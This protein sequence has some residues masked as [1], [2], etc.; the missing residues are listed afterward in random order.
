MYH[1]SK[2]IL[3]VLPLGTISSMSTML[4]IL[5][6]LE[7]KCHEALKTVITG[8]MKN[9]CSALVKHSFGRV[10]EPPSKYTNAVPDKWFS[11]YC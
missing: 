6:A 9:S 1:Y 3:S 8:A 2:E 10:S 5:A 4:H 7:R 11:F